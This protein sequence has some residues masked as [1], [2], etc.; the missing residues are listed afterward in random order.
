MHRDALRHDASR[1][2]SRLAWIQQ[3]ALWAISVYRFG[4]WSKTLTG[5]RG[6]IGHA[7]YYVAFSVVRLA[8]GI[9]IPRRCDIGA[10]LLIHHFGGVVIHPEVHAG[11]NLTLR[12]GVTIGTARDD[13]GVPILGDDVVIGAYAQIIGPVSIGNGVLIGALSLV[14][15][16][17]PA[18]S[19]VAGVPAR[20]VRS[21]S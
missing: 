4:Q 1:Y 11:K 15:K 6:L 7:I 10:G 3:P 20:P 13:G 8:T 17:V 16:D 14:N 21:K 19:V 5:L 18:G 9:E 2:G 12:Q